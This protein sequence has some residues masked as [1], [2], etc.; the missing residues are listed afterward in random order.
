MVVEIPYTDKELDML[1]KLTDACII[2]MFDTRDKR[3]VLGKY[4]RIAFN[5]GARL[6]QSGNKINL[7]DKSKVSTS[8]RK[9]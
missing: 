5:L 1:D 3:W 6:R 2:S 4:L 7:S 8:G 9:K